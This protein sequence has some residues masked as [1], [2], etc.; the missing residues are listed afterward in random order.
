MMCDVKIKGMFCAEDW[1]C[2]YCFDTFTRIDR[3]LHSLAT[4]TTASWCASLPLWTSAPRATWSDRQHTGHWTLV[5]HTSVWQ[6]SAP[7][8]QEFSSALTRLAHGHQEWRWLTCYRDSTLLYESLHCEPNALRLVRRPRSSMQPSARSSTSW[9]KISM[10]IGQAA[11][12]HQHHRM[13]NLA[14]EDVL[15][16]SCSEGITACKIALTTG[17]FMVTPFAT[18]SGLLPDGI[19]PDLH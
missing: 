17:C 15:V 4:L 12:P 8:H 9:A 11:S 18:M 19:I 2:H 13:Q 6:S 5:L 7:M 14:R 1:K 10:A 16:I 3:H